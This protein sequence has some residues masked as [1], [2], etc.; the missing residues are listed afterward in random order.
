MMKHTEV[1]IIE[2]DRTPHCVS[3]G[4]DSEGDIR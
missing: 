4:D 1:K 3:Y 2:I